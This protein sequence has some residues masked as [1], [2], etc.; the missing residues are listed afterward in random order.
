MGKP[1]TKTDA[2][3]QKR[4]EELGKY[5]YIDPKY[6]REERRKAKKAR[7]RHLRNKSKTDARDQINEM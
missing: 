7:T 2:L 1:T 4:F 3:L 5:E 6:Q